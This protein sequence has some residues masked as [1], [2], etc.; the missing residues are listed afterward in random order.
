MIILDGKVDPE[1]EDGWCT[2]L[3]HPPY[4]PEALNSRSFCIQSIWPFPL[5]LDIYQPPFFSAPHR[6][7]FL[8]FKFRVTRHLYSKW[9]KSFLKRPQNRMLMGKRT[10]GN[11]EA[12]FLARGVENTALHTGTNS[13]TNWFWSLSWHFSKLD[14][15]GSGNLLTWAGLIFAIINLNIEES[16]Y[17]ATIIIQTCTLWTIFYMIESFSNFP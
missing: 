14:F 13:V 7:R 9:H 5:G 8:K 2:P 11:S 16:R 3:F 10:S 1:L 6:W 15:S 4:Q 17:S 12:D